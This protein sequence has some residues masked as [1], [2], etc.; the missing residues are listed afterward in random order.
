MGMYDIAAL[1]TRVMGLMLT[2]VYYLKAS[3]VPTFSIYLINTVHTCAYYLFGF[4]NCAIVFCV[5]YFDEESFFWF[6][7]QGK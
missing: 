5:T 7:I 6:I 3:I 2:Y 1:S 4:F